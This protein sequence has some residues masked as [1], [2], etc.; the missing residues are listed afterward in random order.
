MIV[1]VQARECKAVSNTLSGLCITKPPCRE[2]C[3]SEGFTD[4]KCSKILKRCICHKPCVFDE[5][6]VKTGAETLAEEVK[7]LAAAL[8]EED[9]MDN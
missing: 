6:M 4:G 1:E 7:T 3:I 8:L 2:A 9:I 5:K